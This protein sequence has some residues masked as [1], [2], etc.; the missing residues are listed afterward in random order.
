MGTSGSFSGVMRPGLEADH[1]P[2]TTAEVKRNVDLYRTRL[3]G[4][5]LN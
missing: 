4:V 1:S 2:P 3:L 5:V